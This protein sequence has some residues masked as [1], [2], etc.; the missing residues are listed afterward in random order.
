MK[1]EKTRDMAA[2]SKRERAK[3]ISVVNTE[4]VEPE[5]EN[6]TPTGSIAGRWVPHEPW[7]KLLS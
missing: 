1:K 3:A 5:K 7:D 6:W 4:E 2:K